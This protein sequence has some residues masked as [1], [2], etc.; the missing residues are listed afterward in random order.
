MRTTLS[1]VFGICALF[2]FAP[3][4]VGTTI[5]PLGD[6]IT[7]GETDP[8]GGGY[9]TKLYLDLLGGGYQPQFVG[10]Q[11]DNPSQILLSAGQTH[12]DGLPGWKIHDVDENLDAGS[13]FLTRTP[14]T[15][16][17]LLLLG[18]ND[19]LQH[20]DTAHAADR[21]DD[22]IDR[23]TTLRPQ[24]TVVVG[25]I[26][27]TIFTDVHDPR[28][29]TMM[30]NAAIPKLVA[31]DRAAG[32]SVYFADMFPLFL[33]A[34]GDRNDNMLSDGIHP[35]M[36]AYDLMGDRWYSTIRSMPTRPR[37]TLPTFVPEPASASAIV[38]ASAIVATRRMGRRQRSRTRNCFCR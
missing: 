14:S 33:T 8:R 37:F 21:L 19:M 2:L 9:R 25:S 6:S 34:A 26:P 35:S 16:I 20:F 11:T 17:I 30:Y 15:N 32:K 7:W 5:F 24:S 36:A 3:P 22:M 28:D 10:T 38:L 1:L 29:P 23:L 12:H 31:T 13:S 4:A 18:T 27:P